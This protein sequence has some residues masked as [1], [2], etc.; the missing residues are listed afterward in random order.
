MESRIWPRAFIPLTLMRFG[1]NYIL[2][3]S[4]VDVSALLNRVGMDSEAGEKVGTFAF[5]DAALSAASPI[6]FSAD[7]R[8]DTCRSQADGKRKINV[9]VNVDVDTNEAE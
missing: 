7:C 1:I 2:V 3:D 9:D 8:I 6:R 4:S 5:A